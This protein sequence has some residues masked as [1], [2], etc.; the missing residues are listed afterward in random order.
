LDLIDGLT[1]DAPVSADVALGTEEP[2][3]ADDTLALFDALDA[4]LETA[5][6]P[7]TDLGGDSTIDLSLGTES[8]DEAMS[9]LDLLSGSLDD[10]ATTADFDLF[11]AGFGDLAAV[12]N[13]PT[14]FDGKLG[15]GLEL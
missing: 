8:I 9:T 1:G 13:D 3:A 4:E 15:G 11:D 14:A 10:A 5:V 2:V 12:A 6:T 7:D